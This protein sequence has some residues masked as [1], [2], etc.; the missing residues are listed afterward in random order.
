MKLAKSSGTTKKKNFLTYARKW[1]NG[2][3][4]IKKNKLP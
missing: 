2:P 3:L 1:K 4:K